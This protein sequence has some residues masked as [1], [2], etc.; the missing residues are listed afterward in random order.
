[1]NSVQCRSPEN[2]SALFQYT[3]FANASMFGT[4]P[5]RALFF[6]FPEE[7]EL[8]DV[9]LQWMVGSD[10]LVTPVM[11]PNVST[12]DGERSCV[13]AFALIDCYRLRLL[14]WPR[15]C[16][17]AR[18]VY[19]RGG[20][21]HIRWHR[22]TPCTAG[23]HPR[24]HPFRCRYPPSLSTWLHDQRDSPVRVLLVSLAT[25]GSAFGSDDGITPQPENATL[26]N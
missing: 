10:I 25:D 4:P 1:M 11:T 20:E 9:D 15:I 21:R 12:V 14:P 6:E 22:H 26:S 18:L 24:P 2:N 13:A 8:F 5:V 17:L 19:S 16:D 3:L 23:P 7:P